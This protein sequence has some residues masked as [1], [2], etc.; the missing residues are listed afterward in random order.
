[1]EGICVRFD[2]F[3]PIPSGMDELVRRYV[4]SRSMAERPDREDVVLRA[5]GR[6]VAEVGDTLR[7]EL[8][9]VRG[10]LSAAVQAEAAVCAQAAATI[11]ARDTGRGELVGAVNRLRQFRW[12]LVEGM[13][14]FISIFDSFTVIR[15]EGEERPLPDNAPRL[16]LTSRPA[17]Q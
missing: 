9:E 14:T 10:Q 2:I 16:S 4:R 5:L 11:K 13:S 1:M 15:A 7:N 12:W 8:G 17:N 3:P 6:E